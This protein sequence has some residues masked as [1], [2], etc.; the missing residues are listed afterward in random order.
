MRNLDHERWHLKLI[1]NAKRQLAS[2]A[3][4]HQHAVT[5]NRVDWFGNE[6]TV[7]HKIIEQLKRFGNLKAQ[8]RGIAACAFQNF[9]QFRQ[10]K[11]LNSKHRLKGPEWDVFVSSAE[12]LLHSL[13]VD[14][15]A[16][17]PGFWEWYVGY[18]ESLT[19]RER[20]MF[21]DFGF[22]LLNSRLPIWLSKEF[23]T[24]PPRAKHLLIMLR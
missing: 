13:I 16:D 11:C 6:L 1:D 4:D 22:G 20:R 18:H 10:A 2:A 3:G 15:E 24:S 23:A 7:T 12:E 9:A 5:L 14:L 17:R 19:D 8:Q 21:T